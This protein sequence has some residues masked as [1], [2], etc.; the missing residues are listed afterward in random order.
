MGTELNCHLIETGLIISIHIKTESVLTMRIAS[1]QLNISWENRSTNLNQ[2]GK[3]I[4]RAKQ[5]HCDIIIFPEMFASGFSMNADAFAEPPAGKTL[6][7]LSDLAQQQ[8]INIVAGLAEVN[9]G[10]YENIAVYINRNGK[11]KARYVKNYPYSPAGED[12]VFATGED[13]VIFDLDGTKGSL[14]ICYDLRFPELFRTVAQQVEIIFVIANWP[15][16]RQE[17]WETLLK[18][19]AIE[20]QCF[21]VG[22]NRIGSDGNHLNYSGASHVYSPSGKSLSRG[23]AN[24]QYIVT[25]IDLST[26]KRLRLALPFLEDIKNIQ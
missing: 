20:N 9:A 6:A 14:F 18:A 13:Q 1:I 17:H 15:T 7:V 5:D 2:A 3:F 4:Q 24:Q 10:K 22:V 12:K 19:R 16:K 26:V 25:D 23:R 8:Q 21:I 11:V